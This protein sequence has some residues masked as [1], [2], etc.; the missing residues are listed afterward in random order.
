M[1]SKEIEIF[2]EASRIWGDEMQTMM[3]FEEM[4]ELMQ[5]VSKFGRKRD[6]L[7]HMNLLEEIADVEIMLDQLKLRLGSD[8]AETI[9]IIRDRKINRLEY[10]IF[11]FKQKN[12]LIP[13]EKT[14]HEKTM[15]IE[16]N[17]PIILTK[18]KCD[19]C[20]YRTTECQSP[21]ICAMNHKKT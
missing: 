10:A 19:N 4:G 7:T 2:K 1:V 13:E 9:L 8:T 12:N 18:T 21:K 15:D 16:V 14:D 20:E 11:E 6:S 5:S 3:L 17:E